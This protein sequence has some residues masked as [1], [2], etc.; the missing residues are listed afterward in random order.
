[1]EIKPIHIII[2]SPLEILKAKKKS[3][4]I[5]KYNSLIKHYNKIP[6]LHLH[7]SLLVTVLLTKRPKREETERKEEMEK[8]SRKFSKNQNPTVILQ[9]VFF[10]PRKNGFDRQV[11]QLSIVN[12]LLQHHLLVSALMA[13]KC[14]FP[15][16]ND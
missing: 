5:R 7:Q 16:E 14:L 6:T 9:L 10:F 12:S 1:M 3:G 13:A 11:Y 2:S 15:S 8:F 4:R